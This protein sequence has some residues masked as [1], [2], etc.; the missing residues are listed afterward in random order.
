M[1]AAKLGQENLVKLLLDS[2][3]D[4]ELKNVVRQDALS[5]RSKRDADAEGRK[6]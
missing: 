2:G 5:L 3:A 1:Y 4:T 6:A